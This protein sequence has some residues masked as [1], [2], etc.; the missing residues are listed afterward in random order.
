MAINLKNITSYMF[1]TIY[2][3]EDT[4]NKFKPYFYRF[5]GVED[6]SKYDDFIKTIQ[7]KCIE[8]QDKCIIFD[9]SIPLS[10]EMELIQYIFNELASMDV[11]KITSQDITIFDDLEINFKFLSALEYII[12]IA[13]NKENFFNENVRN[14][15]ITKLIVW[16]YT[17]AKDI[18]YDAN[19]NP[20][21]IYYGNI[22]RHEIYFLIMLYK[23]GFDVIYINPLKEELW[24]EIE[25]NGLSECIKS[26]GIL[27]IE[28]FREKANRGKVI[29]NF[30]TI[31]KQVQR[32]IEEQLFS[33][34]GM[35]KPWQFRKGYT[36]SVLLDTILEDIYIYWNEPCKLRSGFKVE[37]NIV[38]VPCFFKKIDGVYSDEFEYQKL[39]K[40]CTSS[41]NTLVFNGIYFSEDVQFKDDMYQLMFCQLSDG[42]FDIEEIKKLPLYRFSKYSE[43]VQNFLLNKF[44]E[45]ISSKDLFSRKFNKE[46]ILRLLVLVLGLNESIV[47]LIDNFDFTGAIPKIVIYLEDEN[48]MPES[49][50][51][52]LG[53][54]H[55]IGIDIVIFNPSGLFNIN[56]VI[57]E[58]ALNDFRLDVMKYD[59]KYNNLINLK[60]GVFS[61]F[62]R[63]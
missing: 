49:M 55:T 23:M 19:I 26:M 52:L 57:K 27:N 62:L 45:T 58:T 50:Q 4:Y 36:K 5:I 20:K 37:G 18:K 44:N 42:S 1:R 25:D 16:T 11:Y 61:R 54:I 24:N 12:P 32:D 46:E 51:I 40:Y 22:Q 28:S 3:R 47:R 31:T 63:K 2:E 17:Y 6:S 14:N 8:E 34:T 21:C 60:Q 43:D 48:T 56:N 35:F 38:Q 41:Q 29:D 33:N 53:Y 59:S 30:E 10:G 39:V 7:S 9:N 13:C 15:F